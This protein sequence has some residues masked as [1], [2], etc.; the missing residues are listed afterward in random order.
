MSIKAIE[1][2]YAGHRFRSRLEARWAVFFDKLGIAWEYE[3]EG[4]ETPHGRYLPD[5]RLSLCGGPK[6]FEVKPNA[7]SDDDDEPRWRAVVE[8]TKTDLVVAHGMPN[9]QRPSRYSFDLVW[10]NPDSANEWMVEY[11]ESTDPEVGSVWDNGR[12]FSPCVEGVALSFEGRHCG[13]RGNSEAPEIV[14]AYLAAR[15]ARFEFGESG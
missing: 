12:A 15:K 1:T 2:H 13:H 10:D 8:G 7:E 5:F 3:P 4:Y 9:P 14:A 6:W 11:G